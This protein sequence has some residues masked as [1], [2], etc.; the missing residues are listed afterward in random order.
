LWHKRLYM[1]QKERITRVAWRA[2]RA[3]R[4]LFSLQTLVC[5]A[6]DDQQHTESPV[7]RGLPGAPW[8]NRAGSG[9]SGG[10]ALFFQSGMSEIQR[11][12]ELHGRSAMTCLR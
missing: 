12:H 8:F 7:C 9:N 2:N 4:F 1:R 6:G 11:L 10:T 5:T 3:S